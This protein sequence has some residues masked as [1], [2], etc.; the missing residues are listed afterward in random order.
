[1]AAAVFLRESVAPAADVFFARK[2]SASGRCFIRESVTPV[3]T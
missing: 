3:A 2:R 1:V